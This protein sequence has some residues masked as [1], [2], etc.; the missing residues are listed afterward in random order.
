[1]PR[2]F[3]LSLILL[4]AIF[5][6]AGAPS[7]ARAFHE[8]GVAPCE[9]CHTMHN[10]LDN[11]PMTQSGMA[12]ASL[13]L[14][15]SA[16]GTCLNCHQG[17]TA[18]SYQVATSDGALPP[19][20]PPAMMTPGGDFAWLKKSYSWLVGGTPYNETGDRHGHNIVS[21]DFGYLADAV[22]IS[23]PGGTF[24]AAALQC[25]SCHDPHGR[26]RVLNDGTV[27]TT[28]KPAFASGSYSV[29]G[30][31]TNP[32]V[33]ESVGTY[34]LLAGVGYQPSGSG[35]TFVNGPPAAMAPEDYNRSEDLTQTRVAYGAGTSLWC[36]NCHDQMHTSGAFV[37]PSDQAVGI[38][39]ADRYNAYIKT[40]DLTGTIDQAF[41]SLV[42]FE[43]GH[44]NSLADRNSL[45]AMARSDDSNLYGP[46]PQDSVGC[47]TCHRAHASGWPY[48]LRWNNDA[49][50]MVYN[51]FYPGIDNGVPPEYSMGRTEAETRR[52]YYDRPA[53]EFASN[54]NRLCEKCHTN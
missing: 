19:G 15:T 4:A 33:G 45:A 44:T 17:S 28:S 34:R 13:L 7:S 41:L 25:T 48:M 20:I 47:L 51:G 49:P 26:Y 50:L 46:G 12:N 43:T 31:P 35:I 2:Q 14:N 11:M 1:M 6:M 8:G 52:S 36:V 22:N 27:S 39:V 42:P 32:Q 3:S 40:G 24:S 37:H 29:N 21:L 18:S 10:S 16:S 23:A 38:T 54:Q 30:V 9:G 5:F 53:S